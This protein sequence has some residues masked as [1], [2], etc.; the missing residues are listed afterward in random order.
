MAK[1]DP[2]FYLR[3]V[4]TGMKLRDKMLEEI[5]EKAGYDADTYGM[6]GGSMYNAKIFLSIYEDVV[7]DI[8]ENMDRLI[9]EDYMQWALTGAVD[10]NMT[11]HFNK[12]GYKYEAA[13][14][15]GEVREGNLDYPVIHQ[16]KENY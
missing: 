8:E 14:W 11:Y 9:E 13:P 16:W 1:I 10:A 3:G 2:P 12:R 5:K 15:L 7:K 6:C 4:R